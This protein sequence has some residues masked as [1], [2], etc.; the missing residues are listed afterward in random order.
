MMKIDLLLAIMLVLSAVN[1]GIAVFTV[2][3]A[4]IC[5]WLC[6]LIAQ[7]QYTLFEGE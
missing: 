4:A 3:F 2:N 6:A 5:G 1:L 7:L